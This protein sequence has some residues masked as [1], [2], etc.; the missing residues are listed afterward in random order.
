MI[1]AEAR[2]EMKKL[3][4]LIAGSG[5]VFCDLQRVARESWG[6]NGTAVADG[7]QACS[8][9]LANNV[10]L[11]TLDWHLAKMTGLEA[12]RWMR[13]VNLKMQPYIILLTENEHPE[14]V[15]DAYL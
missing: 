9:I 3:K 13:T 8:A 11:C 5:P 6:L 10:D 14:H 15:R 4:V 12:C 1:F 7:K 2:Q